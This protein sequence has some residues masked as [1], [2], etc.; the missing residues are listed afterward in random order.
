MLR[1]AFILAVSQS[2]SFHERPPATISFPPCQESPLPLYISLHNSSYMMLM[3]KSTSPSQE[4]LCFPW[5]KQLVDNFSMRLLNFLI[6]LWW[7]GPI[8]RMLWDCR[9]LIWSMCVELVELEQE[10]WTRIAPR[11]YFSRE[12]LVNQIKGVVAGRRGSNE[13]RERERESANVSKEI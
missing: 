3:N 2:H 4:L 9:P 1:K 8:A 6:N 12:Q 5:W 13:W 7:W 11:Y 10:T